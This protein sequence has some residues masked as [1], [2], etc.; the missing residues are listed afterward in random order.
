MLQ[1]LRDCS[2]IIA[3]QSY[4]SGQ[5]LCEP[6]LDGAFDYTQRKTWVSL[7]PYLCKEEIRVYTRPDIVGLPGPHSLVLLQS[8]AVITLPNCSNQDQG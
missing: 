6:S 7:D 2:T 1:V 3:V 4:E 5:S 8:N